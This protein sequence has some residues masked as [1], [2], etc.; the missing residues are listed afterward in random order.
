MLQSLLLLPRSIYTNNSENAS[1]F[2]NFGK[3]S[4]NYR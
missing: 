2:E 1:L 4:M 3:H